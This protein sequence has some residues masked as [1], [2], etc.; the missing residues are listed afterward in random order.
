MNTIGRKEVSI[1][2]LLS[3]KKNI[4]LSDSQK[5]MDRFMDT[6]NKTK[7]GSKPPDILIQPGNKG[8]RIK[9]VEFD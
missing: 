6:L 4:N 2:S 5:N 3:P 1:D 9:D 8:T 7:S